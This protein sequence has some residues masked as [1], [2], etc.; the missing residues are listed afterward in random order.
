MHV[1]HNNT[2]LTNTTI[3]IAVLFVIAKTWKQLKGLLMDKQNM[4]YTWNRMSVSLQKRILIHAPTWM[5]LRSCGEWPAT[6]L[7]SRSDSGPRL[8]LVF[9]G[10]MCFPMLSWDSALPW[11]GCPQQ[12]WCPFRLSFRTNKHTQTYLESKPQEEAR[13]CKHCLRQNYWD[14]PC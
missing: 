6:L 11:R 7:R 1:G 14:K 9:R 12:S 10:L 8:S 4:V 2:K 13:I 3:F 5:T